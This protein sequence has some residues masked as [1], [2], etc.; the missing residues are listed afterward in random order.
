[1]N[2]RPHPPQPADLNLTPLVDVV[3]LLLLF[4]MISTTFEQQRELP[5][6][7][8]EAKGQ[9]AQKTDRKPLAIGIDRN[10]HYVVDGQPLDPGSAEQ[11][12]ERLIIA[13]RHASAS[14]K[15]RSLLIEADA[16]TPHQAVMRVLD[17]AQEVGLTQLAFAATHMPDAENRDTPSA[18]AMPDPAETTPAQAD[19]PPLPPQ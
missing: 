14:S 19:S 17:A 15:N 4:F 2:L 5:I 7:L 10:S 1:M 13:L 16:Q 8:P 3:F 18:P 9:P 12:R 6:A 11:T